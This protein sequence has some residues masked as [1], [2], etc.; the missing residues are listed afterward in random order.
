[1]RDG[2]EGPEIQGWWTVKLGALKADGFIIWGLRMAIPGSIRRYGFEFPRA[3]VI[4]SYCWK[5]EGY[6]I[7]SVCSLASKAKRSKT[8]P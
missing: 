4:C 5:N 3:D 2:D 7:C 1:M 8:P 6:I